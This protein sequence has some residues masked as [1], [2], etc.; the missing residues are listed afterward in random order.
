[1]IANDANLFLSNK[2]VTKVLNDMNVDLQKR[3]K[4]SLQ[5]QLK[6]SGHFFTHK[7]SPY[8]KRFTHTLHR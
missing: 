4:S 1:M 2:D 3:Q 8:C 7:K 5:I 6:R